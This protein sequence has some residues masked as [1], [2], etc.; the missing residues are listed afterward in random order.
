VTRRAALAVAAA[1][2][3]LVAAGCGGGGGEPT[4]VALT[5]PDPATLAPADAPFFAESVARPEGEVKDAL[6]GA[7]SKLLA[8]DDPGGFIVD[9]LDK[10]LAEGKTR[11]TYEE[12]VAPWLGERAG[13]F[14][15]TFTDRNADGAAVVDTTDPAAAQRAIDKAAAADKTP[16][17]NRTYKGVD[18][19][20]DHKG[21]A[22]G[23]VGDFAVFGTEVAFRDAVDASRGSSLADSGEFRSELG[24]APDGQVAFVFADP[25]RVVDALE[26]AGQVTAAEVAAAGPQLQTLLSAPVAA[27]VG[28]TADQLSIEASAAASSS[29]PAPQESPLLRQFPSDSWFAFA[30][31]D[32]G[33]FYGQALAQG[34]AAAFPRALGF[35]LGSELG[36]WAGDVGG[37]VG[38][39]SLFGLGGA[40]VV[41]TSD[42]QASA[43]TLA[44]LRDALS[45]D[46]SVTVSPLDSQGEQGFSLS[47]A[48]V[49]VQ[50]QVVQRDGKVVAG[51]GD[52]V[53]Q[54]FSP[55]STLDDSGAFKSAVDALGGDFSPVTF[56]DF[57]PLL[58]L[59]D[60][61]PQAASDPGYKRA[62]PYLDHLDYLVLGGRAE[63][64]RAAVRIV[65]GLQDAPSRAT[66][67]QGS[68]G[69]PAVGRAPLVP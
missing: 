26:K 30:A 52:A 22:A 13:I 51:L 49:P 16:E 63:G 34:G 21:T 41:E 36:H 65:L 42:E 58:Q 38:G 25:R 48:G 1:C 18:Y 53:D 28:A 56:L 2:A 66:S 17:R 7:L 6:D 23:M 64:S 4:T 33:R 67:T 57:G 35:D 19:K 31:S 45:R 11:L 27:S 10:A 44:K 46:Q 39:T 40:L 32:A 5:G 20:V 29:A 60:G 37:F 68:S 69:A 15:E 61:F 24:A 47:P 9:Q 12:D 59:I 50:F 14:F 3:A 8:T 62:K 43:Q 54:A 55:S